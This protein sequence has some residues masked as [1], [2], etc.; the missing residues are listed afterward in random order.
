MSWTEF[1]FHQKRGTIML[2]EGMPMHSGNFDYIVST[3]WNAI[4]ADDD[5]G[6]YKNRHGNN[7]CTHCL[8][9]AHCSHCLHW[10]DHDAEGN[11]GI[12]DDGHD[13]SFYLGGQKVLPGTPIFEVINAILVRAF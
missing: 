5:T 8:H 3:E 4:M 2:R 12:G 11:Y 10:E 13:A 1:E 7:S 6:T 9:C